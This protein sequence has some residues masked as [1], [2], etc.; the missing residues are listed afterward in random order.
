MTKLTIF[1]STGSIGKQTLDVISKAEKGAF[2]I[3]ALTANSNYQ[4]LAE[5]ALEFEPKY[6]VIKDETKYLALKETLRGT[7]VEVLSGNEGIN[8]V[9]SLDSNKVVAGISGSAGL[10]STYISL[11]NG[12]DVLFA[13]KESLVCAGQLLK[14]AARDANSKLIPLD[15]EHNAIFQVLEENNRDAIK[16]I[17]LTASGGPFRTASSEDLKNVTPEKALKHPNWVM[18]NKVT[19]DCATLFNKGLELIEAY[20]LFDMP[21]EQIDVIVHPQ[22]IVHSMVTYNDGSTLAQLGPPDMKTPITHSLYWPSRYGGD[23]I[24]KPL[25]FS[26]IKSLDFEEPRHELFPS[27]NLCGHAVRLGRSY[28]AALNAANEVAVDLFLKG[29]IKFLDIFKLV[30]SYLESHNPVEVKSIEDLLE[31]DAEM[32]QESSAILSK[33]LETK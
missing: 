13:N 5:Q 21:L 16:K 33:S 25:D 27:I 9:A 29:E 4:T 17:T 22:S 3:I 12:A 23:S 20:H 26:Q 10:E 8:Q 6:V 24:V 14:D 18:G 7:K 2:E 15:S 19:I 1:G 32:K 30:E 28:P 11:K 31:L